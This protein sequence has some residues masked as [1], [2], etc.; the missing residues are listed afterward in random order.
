MNRDR[1]LL[2]EKITVRPLMKKIKLRKE[3]TKSL[4][5]CPLCGIE[6]SQ[7]SRVERFCDSCREEENLYKYGLFS[8]IS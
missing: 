5:T 2:S 3:R 7:R 8:A 1:W 6:F 4:C